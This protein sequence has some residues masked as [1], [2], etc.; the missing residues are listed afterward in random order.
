LT[1][2][3]ANPRWRLD[4][5][6]SHAA[7]I[8]RRTAAAEIRAG[9]VQVNGCDVTR[10]DQPVDPM[11]DQV[12]WRGQ[13][14]HLVGHVV[15]VQH[16]TAG[17]VTATAGE[18][19][20]TVIDLVPAALRR[21]GLAPVGRLDRDTT[22]LL[23]LTTDGDLNHRLTHPRRH[24]DKVYRADLAGPLPADAA[25]QLAR[26]LV[27]DDGPCLPASLQFL[28]PL[29]VRLTVR[30]GRFHQVKRMILAL[31]SEVTHLHRE[32][33][34][35]LALPVDLLPGQTRELTASELALLLATDPAADASAPT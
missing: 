14:V 7:G 30:E 16:K 10:D 13:A 26:G 12:C 17:V 29:Q 34:G 8:P 32:K 31:G 27:L 21:P 6:L 15:L 35:A 3:K 1:A 28:A 2:G 5:L 24:V 9:Q 4:R 25:E 19:G 20:R 18:P 33:L 11:R 22:G 23:I